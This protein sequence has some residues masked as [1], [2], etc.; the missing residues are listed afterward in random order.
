MN[1]SLL[2]SSGDGGT[3]K[4]LLVTAAFISLLPVMSAVKLQLSL[5]ESVD[6]TEGE[7]VT[8]PCSFSPPSTVSSDLYITWVTMP[9]RYIIYDSLLGNLWL[10]RAE[11][12]GDKEKG[13]CSLR[14]LNVTRTLS[15]VFKCDV[16]CTSCGTNDWKVEREVKLNVTAAAARSRGETSPTP[17]VHFRWDTVVTV[18]IVV[19]GVILASAAVIFF[20]KMHPWSSWSSPRSHSG[21][22]QADVDGGVEKNGHPLMM[23]NVKENGHPLMMVN[24]KEIGHPLMMVNV[25]EN[26]HPLMEVNVKDNGHPLT[27]VN[28]KENGHPLMMVNV[29]E[30][31]HPLMMVN[32]K[33]N[34]HPLMMV[35][36]K[37]NGHPLMMVNVKEN[38]HPLMEVNVKEN[39]HPLM[40]VNVKENG[41]PLMVNEH[42]GDNGDKGTD[43]V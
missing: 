14:L 26:G 7:S 36:V 18:V 19:A 35:N 38:G 34:G 23:V 41:H 13:D 39:G 42:K 1:H 12:A 32:V 33:E 20:I 2:C 28:V 17:R 6:V 11:F 37:E 40:M 31:G 24:V 27:M 4:W 25:K 21:D 43:T 8:L 9:T 30:N 15:P 10:G 29:K 3:M 16:L 5:P 22:G